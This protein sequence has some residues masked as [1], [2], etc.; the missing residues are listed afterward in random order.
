MSHR[1]NPPWPRHGKKR[2]LFVVYAV[3]LCFSTA[4]LCAVG[5]TTHRRAWVDETQKGDLKEMLDT[6]GE[7]GPEHPEVLAGTPFFGPNQWP[8]TPG[9]RTAW[10]AY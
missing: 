3:I 9:F 8:S 5:N 2:R 10:Q 7:A 1:K 4:W 6:G